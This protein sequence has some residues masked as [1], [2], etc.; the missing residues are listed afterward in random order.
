VVIYAGSGWVTNLTTPYGP[1]TF[2]YTYESCGSANP[3]TNDNVVDV[4]KRV[5][6]KATVSGYTGYYFSLTG[7]PFNLW[8]MKSHPKIPKHSQKVTLK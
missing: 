5:L 7:T 4:T 2:A 6:P 8:P 3:L 1:T